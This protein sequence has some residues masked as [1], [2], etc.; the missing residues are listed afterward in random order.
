MAT[1]RTPSPPKSIPAARWATPPPVLS[2]PPLRPPYAVEVMTADECVKG[3]HLYLCN[4]PAEV[5][6][7][8]IAWEK[9][10]GIDIL[11]TETWYEDLTI[12]DRADVLIIAEDIIKEPHGSGVFW[13]VST[14][15]D[16]EM[17]DALNTDDWLEALKL[18]NGYYYG[19]KRKECVMCSL[20][21]W[22]DLQA[23]RGKLEHLMSLGSGEEH[24]VQPVLAM[25]QEA[26]HNELCWREVEPTLEYANGGETACVYRKEGR[27]D[28]SLEPT[29]VPFHLLGTNPNIP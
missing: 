27:A 24:G 22:A 10:K 28:K 13:A 19:L 26:F 16:D 4:E 21:E 9:E 2:P 5:E 20:K 1:P 15:Y 18:T 8:L 7:L 12:P 11:R 3:I 17:G 6:D 29:P 14:E 23:E 25:T